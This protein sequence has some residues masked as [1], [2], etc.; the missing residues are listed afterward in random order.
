MSTVK[1]KS[2]EDV[3]VKVKSVNIL[4]LKVTRK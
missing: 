4:G 3:I 1:L 2:V